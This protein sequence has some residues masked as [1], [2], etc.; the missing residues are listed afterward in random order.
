MDSRDFRKME[1]AVK[2]N[3]VWMKP[4]AEMLWSAV[5]ISFYFDSFK[6]ITNEKVI[7]L[8]RRHTV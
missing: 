6:I 8:V 5:C 7:D 4:P 3:T 2:I 1:A